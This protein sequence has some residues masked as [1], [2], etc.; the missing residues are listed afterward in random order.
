MSVTASMI[1]VRSKRLCAVP[2]LLVRRRPIHRPQRLPDRDTEFRGVGITP[3]IEFLENTRQRLGPR[4]QRIEFGFA[5][6]GLFAG[7]QSGI[8][9][10]AQTLRQD[11]VAE[12]R[13]KLSKLSIAE[14]AHLEVA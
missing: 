5:V 14:R 9:K 4:R 7:N 12:F 1:R 11:L 2:I 6:I 3:A 10:L 8:D 13:H